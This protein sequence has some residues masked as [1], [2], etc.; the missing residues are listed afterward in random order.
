MDF[1]TKRNVLF[2]GAMLTNICAKTIFNSEGTLLQR[3]AQEMPEDGVLT[4]VEQCSLTGRS[5]LIGRWCNDQRYVFM[6]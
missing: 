5:L 6:F 2:S 4:F 1:F 3:Y